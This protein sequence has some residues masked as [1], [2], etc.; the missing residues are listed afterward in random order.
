MMNETLRLINE[1]ISIKEG[2]LDKEIPDE[3][4]NTILEAGIRAPTASSM[5]RYSIIIIKDKERRKAIGAY[6]C[7]TVLVFNVDLNRWVK[8]C[9]SI[10][11]TYPFSGVRHLLTGMVDALLCAENI[12]IAAQSL[13]VG[14]CFTNSIFKAGSMSEIFK[15]LKL[16]KY[17][18]PVIALCLG[19]P[20]EWPKRK[21][22][23]LR[24]GIFHNETYHDFSEE[25][26]EGILQEYNSNGFVGMKDLKKIEAEGFEN[27]IEWFMKEWVQRESWPP[28][29]RRDFWTSL[30]ESGFLDPKYNGLDSR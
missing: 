5:Q 24:R 4:M 19:Y 25:D 1:R 20:K 23:R 15:I 9:E 29:K 30:V 18:F 7:S 22:S 3:L 28:S 26:I 17:V 6:P 21:R 10:G 11:E 2:F 14:S 8:M 13:G 12:V 27:Y 16:P